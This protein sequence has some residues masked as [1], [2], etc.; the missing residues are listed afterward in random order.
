MTSSAWML[1]T[2]A[3]TALIVGAT[4]APAVAGT[5]THRHPAVDAVRA[6][7]PATGAHRGRL[8]VDVRVA[9]RGADAPAR[10]T[11]RLGLIV[12]SPRG[13]TLGRGEDARSLGTTTRPRAIVHR[14]VLPAS[15][16]A[17]AR[18]AG[19]LRLQL[20]AR[21]ELDSDRRA[22]G[23]ETIR[24]TVVTRTVTPQ[25]TPAPAQASIP[26]RVGTYLSGT[27]PSV[28]VTVAGTANPRVTSLA[29][30][31]GGCSVNYPNLSAPVAADGTFSLGQEPGG[32]ADVQ[33]KFN[34]T[35]LQISWNA[36]SAQN[37]IVPAGNNTATWVSTPRTG[38]YEF[39]SSPNGPWTLLEI[40]NPTSPTLTY[41]AITTGLCPRGAVWDSLSIPVPPSGSFAIG[42]QPDG[43]PLITGT[44]VD[45]QTIG[46]QWT[47]T[48]DTGRGC[49]VPPGQLTAPWFKALGG[50][51]PALPNPGGS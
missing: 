15:T 23:P 41:L 25:A 42:S 44:V 38:L 35:A 47:T 36:L 46:L 6:Y 11:S 14:I 12:R 24:R 20:E 26:V 45:Q 3:A 32:G 40:D 2:A 16:A 49:S 27:D 18:R 34:D 4:A 30:T 37:C 28:S 33:G 5:P 17:A 19:T 50:P 48:L 21:T 22:P 10:L 8:V 39:S 51:R 9:H 1:K 31:S 7:L 13:A 29:I 43:K